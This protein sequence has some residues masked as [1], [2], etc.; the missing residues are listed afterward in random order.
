MPKRSKQERQII[1]ATYADNDIYLTLGGTA[2]QAYFKS[3]NLQPSNSS[4]DTTA[5]AGTDWMERAPG[6]NDM[7][8]SVTLMYDAADVQTYIQKLAVGQVISIEYGPEGNSA[9]KPRHVQT[10]N[11]TGAAHTVS[12]DKSAVTFEFTGESAAAPS[13]NLFAGAV[14]SS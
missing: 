1:I 5:G 7:K 13:F 8:I 2:V 9:G 11:V 3:V 6:L 10:F 12:V 14:Y 4:V